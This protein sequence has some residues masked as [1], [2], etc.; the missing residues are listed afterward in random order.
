M[1]D[2][3]FYEAYEWPLL[4]QYKNNNGTIGTLSLSKGE[5]V[6]TG[7]ESGITGPITFGRQTFWL[8]SVQKEVPALAMT[9]NRNGK[10]IYYFR[11]APS[12]EIEVYRYDSVTGISIQ[13]FLSPE[14]GTPTIHFLFQLASEHS[15]AL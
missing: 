11:F 7:K 3:E 4:F 8:R 15:C 1:D 2:L 12:R 14:T 6:L 10:V 9:L 5:L 13:G